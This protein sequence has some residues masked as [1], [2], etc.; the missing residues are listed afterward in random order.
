MGVSIENQRFVNRADLLRK[1]TARG[2]HIFVA[3]RIFERLCGMSYLTL[4]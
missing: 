3:T 1:V 4:R 2:V